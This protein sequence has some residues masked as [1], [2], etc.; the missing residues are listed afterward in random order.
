CAPRYS[1]AE[2][3]RRVESVISSCNSRRIG[4]HTTPPAT[5][6]F[7]EHGA[8]EGLDAVPPGTGR[9]SGKWLGDWGDRSRERLIGRGIPRVLPTCGQ[10]PC[11]AS[12][13]IRVAIGTAR[14]RW[15]LDAIWEE[16]RGQLRARLLAKDFDTWIAP[17]RATVWEDGELTIE[18]PSTFSLDWIRAHHQEAL[19][20]ALETAAGN[21]AKLKLVVNRSL[22]TRAPARHSVLRAGTRPVKSRL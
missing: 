17:L 16:V 13:D 7:L 22:E 11:V 19:L 20:R 14:G 2:P 6:Y 10:M 8:G 1:D 3:V 9:V 4:V 18:V 12:R 5:H 21:P 15:M